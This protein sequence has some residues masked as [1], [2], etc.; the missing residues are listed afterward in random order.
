M[1]ASAESPTDGKVVQRGPGPGRRRTAAR[2]S[3]S[4]G[5]TRFFLGSRS[6]PTGTPVLEREFQTEN[7]A[8]IESLRSGMTY[9]AVSEF[10]ATA[11]LSGRA[12]Q[13]RKEGVNGTHDAAA[14][15]S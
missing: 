8:M 7:E 6:S 2:Q 13:I 3:E 9:F 5:N 12:P 15:H 14:R 1:A 11:D 4:N 10:R